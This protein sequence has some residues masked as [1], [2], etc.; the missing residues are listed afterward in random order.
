MNDVIARME[1]LGQR[2]GEETFPIVT[3]IGKP[4]CSCEEPE[5]WACPVS[6]QPFYPSLPDIRG[7]DSFQAL[8]LAISLVIELLS[9]FTEQGGVLNEQEDNAEFLFALGAAAKLQKQDLD[10]FRE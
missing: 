6:F 7:V 5:E 9:I 10:K 1:L 4:Y 2:P 8:C 3:E